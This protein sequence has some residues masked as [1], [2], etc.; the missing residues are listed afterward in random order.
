MQFLLESCCSFCI[1]EAIFVSFQIT[2]PP[3]APGLISCKITHLLL[4]Q[5]KP[6]Q[7]QVCW[8]CRS[9]FSI[10]FCSSLLICSPLSPFISFLSPAVREQQEVF[11]V[12]RNKDLS[13]SLFLL[14]LSV[15]V[16][17]WR[18]ATGWRN[19]GFSLKHCRQ[20]LGAKLLQRMN[21]VFKN[22]ILLPLLHMIEYIFILLFFLSRS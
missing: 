6:C 12:H 13:P 1:A 20:V 4:E 10:T 2:L 3:A 14:F 22:T 19:C 8:S 17:C 5:R 7:H 16:V 18:A 11:M 9:N 15:P 21:T